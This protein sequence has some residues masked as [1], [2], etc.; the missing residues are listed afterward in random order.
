MFSKTKCLCCMSTGLIH[1][2]QSNVCQ[3]SY[4]VHVDLFYL[5]QCLFLVCKTPLSSIVFIFNKYRLLSS[6]FNIKYLSRL[7]K[8]DI[9]LYDELH[10]LLELTFPN[11]LNVFFDIIY[12]N[13]LII[14]LHL[15]IESN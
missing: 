12:H 9:F 1:F 11:L 7:F 6:I 3:V 8:F 15:Y 5:L 14:P 10:M 13:S 4:F 2:S